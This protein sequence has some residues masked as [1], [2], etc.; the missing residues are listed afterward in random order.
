MFGFGKTPKNAERIKKAEAKEAELKR[1]AEAKEAENKRKAEEK[2]LATR[3]KTLM[4][5]VEKYVKKGWTAGDVD[6]RDGTAT[7]TRAAVRFSQSST[8]GNAKCVFGGQVDRTETMF[9]YLD[10]K[11]KARI[12]KSRRG[13]ITK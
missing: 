13:I 9:I 5:E 1:I 10:E 6:A 4:K 8:H 2:I 12:S 11:G 7:L 3:R